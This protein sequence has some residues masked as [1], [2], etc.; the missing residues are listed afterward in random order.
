MA[1]N[2]VQGDTR[3]LSL[4]GGGFLGLYTAHVLQ[5]L[6]ARA[7]VPLGRC[8]D[9]IAGTSIG[10]VL[11]LALAFEVPM[12][13][14]VRLFTDHGPRV[15]SNRALPAGA[16]G[17]LLDLTRSVLGPKY[18]GEALRETLETELGH[19]RLADAL[20]ALVL[21]A[22][23]VG[24]CSTKVFKTPH[25][26]SSLGDGELRAV[27][28]A[29]AACAAPAYFPSVRIGDRL[30]ADGGLFAVAPDQVALHELEHF[31]GADPARVSMLSIGT[32][33]A[34][35]QPRE[36]VQEEAGAVGWLSEGRLILTLI[37]VQQQH[38]QA[39]MDDR[40]GE[41][42]LRL[43]ADWPADAGMG[44]DV[45]TADA[46]QRLAALAKGTLRAADAERLAP[47]LQAR[48]KP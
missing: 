47:F 18:S 29:M 41:R 23:D 1:Q 13:R 7:G 40:L 42:Y 15:F 45:A 22:V 30:Y 2:P 31:M 39:M 12:V 36:G 28:V 10:A 8:F 9:L 5:G 27:D 44:I 48:V 34:R 19:W 20:H 24:A 6:E 35:Y 4:A 11:A 14:L 46:A 17:R 21:P 37:S 43:D 25:A 32:A 16:V 33:T 26:Q 3:V 38:V